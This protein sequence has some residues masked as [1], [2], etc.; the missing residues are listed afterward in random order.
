VGS[1]IVVEAVQSFLGEWSYGLSCLKADAASI[2]D[3]LGSAGHAYA[4]VD[5]A[6]SRAA[7]D[8]RR[9]V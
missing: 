6:I 3:Q 2:A 4:T 5:D 7:G 8:I 1:P 9:V